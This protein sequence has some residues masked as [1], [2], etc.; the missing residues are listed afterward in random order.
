M[1][2]LFTVFIFLLLLSGCALN[3][4]PTLQDVVNG[5]IGPFDSYCDGYGNPGASGAGY[6]SVLTLETGKVRSDMDEILEG[7]VSY[8]RAETLGTYIGQIN[9]I[10]ASSFNGINGAVWGYH[11]AKADSIANNTLEPLFMKKRS[12]GVEIPVYPVEPLLDAGKRLLGTNN[13]RRFPLLPGAHVRCAVNGVKRNTLCTGVGRIQVRRKSDGKHI[14]GFAAEYE[15][16]HK[17]P[18]SIEEAEK[19]TNKM[20]HTSLMGEVTR[21]YASDKYEFFDETHKVSCF[22]VKNKFGTSLVA[23]CWVNYIY[24]EKRSIR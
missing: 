1:K 12:D 15:K 8:D 24:P 3:E 22:K 7:I 18:I 16:V 21:R 13:Q 19:I 4:E 23:L 5:A 17:K 2:R 9:M 11:I 6:I 10:T 14:G 20:L